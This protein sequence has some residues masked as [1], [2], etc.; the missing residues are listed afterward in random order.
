MVQAP[1]N[2]DYDLLREQVRMA[3]PRFKSP[4][5][6]SLEATNGSN[7]DLVRNLLKGTDSE[8]TAVWGLCKVMGI[9]LADIIRGLPDVPEAPEK[10]WLNV[11]GEVEAGAWREQA[12][13]TPAEWY[14]VEVDHSEYRGQHSGLVV[15]GRSMERTLPPGTI[16]RCVDMISA[17]ADWGDG[18]YVIIERRD[19]DRVELTCKKLSQGLDG[20][21]LVA[22]SNQ[23]KYR[24]PIFI[25]RP[26]EGGAGLHFDGLLDE[27]TR[28]R[29]LVIDALLPLRRRRTRPLPDDYWPGS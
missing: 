10:D 11:V 24:E 16:L 18:D 20:W 22:E 4:R 26:V 5:S 27:D 23:E 14:Q 13:W 12:E 29:A 1:S 17:G 2:I 8:F 6:V 15:R 28:V 9:R 21:S 19:G 25:G 7:P 3:L